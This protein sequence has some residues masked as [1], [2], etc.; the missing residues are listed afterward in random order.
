MSGQIHER[1]ARDCFEVETAI[2]CRIEF[3]RDKIE[4]KL[5]YSEC[6]VCSISII[7]CSGR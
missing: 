7:I 2:L 6:Y 5:R 4:N 1:L 3:A